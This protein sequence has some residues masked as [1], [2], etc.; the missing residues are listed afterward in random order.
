MGTDPTQPT[1]DGPD[2][3]T[4]QLAEDQLGLAD[5]ISLWLSG[6]GPSDVVVGNSI[7]LVSPKEARRFRTIGHRILIA[8]SEEGAADL[9]ASLGPVEAAYA[10]A[11]I[12]R[13]ASRYPTSGRGA[14]SELVE[15]AR[16]SE[17]PAET[18]VIDEARG[19]DLEARRRLVAELATEAVRG[20]QAWAESNGES[21]ADVVSGWRIAVM[22]IETSSAVSWGRRT[23]EK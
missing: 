4:Q 18:V 9:V 3:R 23:P 7:L 13:V 16:A 5:A 14:A 21:L 2:H 19:L 15:K 8:E 1:A 22:A 17:A 6:G 20:A 12:C 11:R 10:A